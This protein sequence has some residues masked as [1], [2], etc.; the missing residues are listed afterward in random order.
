MQGETLGKFYVHLFEIAPK[1]TKEIK[2]GEISSIFL[3]L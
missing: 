1:L 2:L 3:F